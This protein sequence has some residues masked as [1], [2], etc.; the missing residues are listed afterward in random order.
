MHNIFPTPN[1][2]IK[3]DDNFIF[4]EK[5]YMTI[6][7]NFSNKDFKALAPELWKNYTAGKSSLEII[8]S[9]NLHTTAYI[10]SSRQA[11][12]Q[13]SKTDFEY[14]IHCRKYGITISFD[15]DTGLI[16]AFC[17]LLQTIPA[18]SLSKGNFT[19]P[20]FEIK[21]KPSLGFRCI[22]LCVFP[23]T[24]LL[25]LKKMI[26]LFGL[27]KC[28]HIILEFFATLKFD[29][30][31][32]L[33]WENGYTKEDIVPII[34]DGKALGIEFIPM[35]NHFGH[36]GG[37]RFRSGKNVVLDNAPEYAEY[38]LPDGWTW[39]VENPDVLILHQKMREELCN[40]FG[41]GKY[42]HIGC[43]EVYAADC[44]CNPYDKED[45]EKFMDF[46]NSTAEKVKQL[47]RTPIMWGDMFLDDKEF[48]Y[49][50]CGNISYRCCNGRENLSKLS[51]DMIIADWQYNIDG[52][53]TE[54]IDYFLERIN[55]ENLLLCPWEGADNIKGRCDIAKEKKLNG[56]IGTTWN[57]IC[58]DPKFAVYTA[59]LMWENAENETPFG[60]WE[61]FKAMSAA[62]IRKLVPANGVY[63][64][65]GFVEEELAFKP[66]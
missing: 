11:I 29:C 46:I 44:L 50:Y 41:D 10:S 22:H 6:P 36:A 33:A 4:G 66:V 42:L 52:T 35:F 32:Y 60:R 16:H 38:F 23:E 43:D 40:L 63:K 5:L 49:P 17:T 24:T 9:P 65:A 18:Y 14:E 47:G 37:S 13:N 45:N 30:F 61:V 26:R 2:Y 62:N 25:F 59:C 21:D 64:D 1:S 7:E 58:R 8:K 19:I 20:C 15:G 53:H 51:K 56:V 28:T 48:P 31:P 54:S 55:P 57:G 12:I 3:T 39:N 27:L 34:T